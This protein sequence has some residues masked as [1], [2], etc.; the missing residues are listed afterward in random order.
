MRS[1]IAAVLSVV[2]VTATPGH[3][4]LPSEHYEN[5]RRHAA[6]HLQVEVQEVVVPNESSLSCHV[7]G[8]VRHVFR[9]RLDL[10]DTDD[11]LG[12]NVLCIREGTQVPPGAGLPQSIAQLSKASYLELFLDLSF[13]SIY[14][15]TTDLPGTDNMRFLDAPSA[16]PALNPPEHRSSHVQLEI[17]S[18]EIIEEGTSLHA[19]I[20]V[21]VVGLVDKIFEDRSRLIHH[22]SRLE[23]V[24][25]CGPSRSVCRR[26][27]LHKLAVHKY[28]ELHLD[29][30]VPMMD[31][32]G[33]IAAPTAQPTCKPETAGRTCW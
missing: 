5:A 4:C 3:T 30:G 6:M 20:E 1:K 22:G 21:K 10:L 16:E 15:K 29:V 25:G 9:D 31:Q 14:I 24:I 28:L 19:A 32:V 18:G 2:A 12:V 13:P 23:G 26:F 17:L 33:I 27:F 7:V 8:K 11:V